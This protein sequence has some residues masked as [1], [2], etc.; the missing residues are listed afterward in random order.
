MSENPLKSPEA[1]GNSGKD[2]PEASKITEK[3]K[4]G[5]VLQV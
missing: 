5:F 1:A 2:A 3:G 4:L